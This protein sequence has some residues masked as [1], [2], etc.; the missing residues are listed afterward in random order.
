MNEVYSNYPRLKFFY[1][2]QWLCLDTILKIYHNY[3]GQWPFHRQYS[4][5]TNAKMNASNK[6]FATTS[7]EEITAKKLK[8]CAE[9]FVQKYYQP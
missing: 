8:M 4:I 7:E 3:N 6:R 1:L 5:E 2:L 9:K